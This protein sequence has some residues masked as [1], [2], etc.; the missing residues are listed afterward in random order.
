MSAAAPTKFTFDLDLAGN[1]DKRRVI[2]EKELERMLAEAEHNGYERGMAEATS[3]DTAKSAQAVAKAAGS[4]ADRMAG[5]AADSDAAIAEAQ[6][7][8]AHLAVT[9]ARKLAAN[10][11]AR[12]PLGE[13]EALMEECMSGLG[14][15]PHLVVRCHPDLANAVK[16]R[17]EDKIASSGFEGRLVVMGDPDIMLGDARFEWKEGG[18]VRDLS[19]LS[20]EI[21]ERLQTFIRS[22]QTAQTGETKS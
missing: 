14:N 21:D 20:A 15:V 12:Q 17:A 10:L 19:Q 22:R 3:A 4:L 2:G 9:T 18:I 11:I 8:A 16:T 5:I 1:A 7:D 13:I 6:A